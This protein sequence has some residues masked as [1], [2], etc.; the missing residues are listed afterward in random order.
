MLTLNQ[1][2]RRNI[3]LSFFLSPLL[4]FSFL[5]FLTCVAIL[6]AFVALISTI[7]LAFVALISAASLVPFGRLKRQTLALVT[8]DEEKLILVFR[9]VEF[10]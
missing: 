1:L 4:A 3:F 8:P 5:L 2:L 10:L 7:S 9:N 6:F